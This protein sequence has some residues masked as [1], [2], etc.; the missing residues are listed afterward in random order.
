MRRN[1][2]MSSL[3]TVILLITFT[4]PAV[5]YSISV[6]E[7]D[8]IVLTIAPTFGLLDELTDTVAILRPGQLSIAVQSVRQHNGDILDETLFA[9]QEEDFSALLLVL[10]SVDLLS[11]PEY[12]DTGV[13]DGH[14]TRI[15]VNWR[16]GDSMSVYGINAEEFGPEGFIAICDSIGQILEN[17]YIYPNWG[18][19]E[20][21]E[22]EDKDGIPL[23]DFREANNIAARI[24]VDPP[25]R[26]A[27]CLY[28]IAGG[29][30]FITENENTVRSVAG[31]LAEM[32]VYDADGWGHTDD[33]LIYTLEWADETT[34]SVTFQSGMLLGN[35][36]ELYPVSNFDSLFLALQPLAMR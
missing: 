9:A 5:A 30:P 17:S 35:R 31:A 22:G 26:A 18:E 6:D 34:F 8:S 27:V 14:F 25:I 11:M 12:I 3:I 23:F 4:I 21:F 15:T 20:P 10:N 19:F 24:A 7:I 33:Y 36:M 2:F 28:T 29:T 32:T 16:N 1:F 13:L